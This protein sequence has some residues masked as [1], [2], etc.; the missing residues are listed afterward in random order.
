[1]LR[2]STSSVRSEPPFQPL[3]P[4]PPHPN[5]WLP[6]L[7]PP[8][9]HRMWNCQDHTQHEC[10]MS[11][12]P[13]G[14]WASA[15]G[16]LSPSLPHQ[17]WFTCPHLSVHLSPRRLSHVS[18]HRS[19]YL[20]GAGALLQ[21]GL[22]NFTLNKL[23]QRVWARMGGLPGGGGIEAELRMLKAERRRYDLYSSHCFQ[24]FT[25]LIDTFHSYV[26]FM[27][28]VLVLSPL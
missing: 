8:A 5:S 13:P 21:H 3:L 2:H 19:Y 27:K 11:S 20:R 26:N 16:C 23:I 22:V 18:G 17:P 7:P 14:S 15:L 12:P 1:M 6:A 10:L 24:S 9:Q 4:S 28:W 25:C